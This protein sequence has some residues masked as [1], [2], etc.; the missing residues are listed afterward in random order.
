MQALKDFFLWFLGVLPDFLL[1]PPISAFV[2]LGLG[3]GT[4]ALL[5]RLCNI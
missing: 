1:T 2:A 5:R 3:A 4:I